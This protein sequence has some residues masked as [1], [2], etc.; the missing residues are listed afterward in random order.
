MRPLEG[1]VTMEAMIL[2]ELIIGAVLIGIL[3]Q[4]RKAPVPVPV[5]RKR[6]GRPDVR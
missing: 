4:P 2:A 3:L 5:R 1:S 6:A